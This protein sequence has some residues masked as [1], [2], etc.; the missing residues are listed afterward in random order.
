MRIFAAGCF[1]LLGASAGSDLQACGD[2]FLV[3]SRGTRFQRAAV[4]RQ[5]AS[6]LVYA[7]PSSDLPKALANVTVDAT[8]RKAGYKPT[9][10]STDGDFNTALRQG[11][12]DLVLVAMA[13]G[14]IVNSRVQ[15]ADAPIVLPVMYNPTGVELAQ[16]KKQYA[17]VLKSPT[18][19]Q[20]FLDAIDDALAAR[21][22]SRSV[23]KTGN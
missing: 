16:A 23:G 5:P 17:R 18:R 6:I 15:G 10:V 9:S 14:Q 13:D 19:S 12:W 21:A 22:H 2:K 3:L 8:L 11:G 1:V 20:S 7:N 4:L